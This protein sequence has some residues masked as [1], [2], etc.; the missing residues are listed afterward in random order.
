MLRSVV[1]IGASLALAFAFLAA[2]NGDDLDD[3]ITDGGDVTDEVTDDPAADDAVVEE[4]EDDAVVEEDD[5]AVEEDDDEVLG[6]TAEEADD[7]EGLEVVED[8]VDVVLTDY[9]IDMPETVTSGIV[10]FA[11]TNE[12]DA[13]HGIAFEL[14][15]SGDE[16]GEGIIGAMFV[17][18][19]ETEQVE[20]EL[21]PGDYVVFCPVGD[22]REEHDME[23]ELTV[24][25]S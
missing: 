20:L 19:G 21:E 22:H 7:E 9:E 14:A 4:E 2:C 5:E 25:E 1:V 16:S 13:P 17:D 24:E 6:H 12:G 11:I 10:V 8:T 18:P 15:G 3:G 23:T